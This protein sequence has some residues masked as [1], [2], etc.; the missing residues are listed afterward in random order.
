MKITIERDALMRLAAKADA[1]ADPKNG[2]PILACAMVAVEG[3]RLRVSATDLYKSTTSTEACEVKNA[4]APVAVSAK[5]LKDIVSNL[6]AGPLT[7]EADAKKHEITIK[8]GR[9]RYRLHTR[10]ADDMPPLPKPPADGWV[11]LEEGSLGRAVDAVS[12]AICTESGRAHLNGA[13]IELVPGG[14]RAVSTDG[15][16]LQR[17]QVARDGNVG[18]SMLVPIGGVR[19][20]STIGKGSASL[21]QSEAFVFIRD[22]ETVS[23]VRLSSEAFPPYEAV[24]PKDAKHKIRIEREPLL[25]ATR[26]VLALSSKTGHAVSIK[27][28]DGHIT[29]SSSNP[30]MGDGIE[31]VAAT[32]QPG[33]KVALDGRYLSASL[34]ACADDH[35]DLWINDELDPV[36]VR[37]EGYTGVVMPQ[38]P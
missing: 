25:R 4:G 38:R 8:S 23:A 29:V 37:G 11:H 20:L 17:V 7:V 3:D 5:Q 34:A 32:C 16:R 9:S 12:F 15:H 24:I 26:A 6:A 21:A 19:L 27:G 13:L 22:G 36:Q 2:M 14:L 18:A 28:E 30:D 10:P 33:A 35:I 1:V 31:E